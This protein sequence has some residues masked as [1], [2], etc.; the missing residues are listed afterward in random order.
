MVAEAEALEVCTQI[1]WL[2]L[3]SAMAVLPGIPIS[4]GTI[5]M[6]ISLRNVAGLG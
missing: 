4:G 2:A 3:P 6:G 5:A 1:L